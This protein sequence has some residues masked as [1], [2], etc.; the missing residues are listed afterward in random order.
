MND[1][2]LALL[3]LQRRFDRVLYVDIDL[4]HGDAV[5]SAFAFSRSVLTLSMHKHERGFF[6]HTGA[7]D[8]EGSGGARWH[9][10]NLPLR[11][12]VHA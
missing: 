3:R 5:Q 6:P 10:L 12:R 2:V 9:V 8:D 11:V 7:L 1:V 4:H